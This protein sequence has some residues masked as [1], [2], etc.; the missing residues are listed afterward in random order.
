MPICISNRRINVNPTMAMVANTVCKEP[1]FLIANRVNILMC[2]AEAHA[3]CHGDCACIVLIVLNEAE[4]GLAAREQLRV[5]HHSWI[6][7]STAVLVHQRSK[8]QQQAEQVPAG[9]KQHCKCGCMIMVIAHDEGKW[10]L[11]GYCGTHPQFADVKC[12]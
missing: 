9:P 4:E 10:R 7:S 12:W 8:A 11:Q 5:K 3:W 6:I 2:I 1:P